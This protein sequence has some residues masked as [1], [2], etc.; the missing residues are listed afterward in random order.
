MSADKLKAYLETLPN[1]SRVR[2]VT[3]S[4][5]GTSYE[6]C[7]YVD[8]N[9]GEQPRLYLLGFLPA[10]YKRSTR[11]AFVID[12]ADWYVAC[13]MQSAETLNN[14]QYAPYHPLGF[15]FML[16]RWAVPDGGAIDRYEMRPYNRVPALVTMGININETV[17]N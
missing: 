6:G 2:I 8:S 4:I 3:V 13:Y 17:L 11:T 15:H 1:V 9:F 7:S 16:C 14:P 12:G 5:K 10:C